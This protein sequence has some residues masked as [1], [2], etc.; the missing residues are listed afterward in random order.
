MRLGRRR[1]ILVDTVLSHTDDDTGD[2][3][4]SSVRPLAAEAARRRVT[5]TGH[6]WARMNAVA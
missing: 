1:A 3:G 4:S 2:D 6:G 5:K